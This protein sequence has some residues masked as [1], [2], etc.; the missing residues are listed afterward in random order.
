MLRRLA[1]LGQQAYEDQPMPPSPGDEPP[2]NESRSTG[3]LAGVFKGLA[4]GKLAKSP[5]PLVSPST[6]G[7]QERIDAAPPPTLLRG[8][9]P[10]QMEL[11]AHLKGGTINERVSAANSLRYA[12]VDFPLNPVR[13]ALPPLTPLAL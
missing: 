5:S 3:G 12:V 7:S 10:H 8:L 13:V 9:P 4:G 6:P 11:F 1:S 2:P